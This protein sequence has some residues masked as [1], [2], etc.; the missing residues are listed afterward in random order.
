M[1]CKVPAN[2]NR[3]KIG[4]VI[5]PCQTL[6]KENTQAREWRRNKGA[7]TKV[8]ASKQ[9]ERVGPQGVKG[10]TKYRILHQVRLLFL[11]FKAK[12]HLVS[13]IR[14]TASNL[15]PKLWKAFLLWIWDLHGPHLKKL[16]EVEEDDEGRT[17]N[18][19]SWLCGWWGY[20]T[21]YAPMHYPLETSYDSVVVP[22][23]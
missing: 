3:K 1:L 18:T 16:L 2:A 11:R 15:K 12:S 4:Q 21:Q 5:K 13:A 8:Q 22:P 19:L 17:L 10:A 20:V 23:G 9:P 14:T 6:W 7:R